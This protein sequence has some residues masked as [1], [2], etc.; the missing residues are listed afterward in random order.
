MAG[1]AESDSTVIQV[2]FT[3]VPDDNPP[4]VIT[5]IL[6][7]PADLTEIEAEAFAG[8]DAQRIVLPASCA[9]VGSRAFADSDSLVEVI[10][11]G[12]DTVIP[13][14]AF[15]GCGQIVTLRLPAGN[16]ST[17][18]FRDNPMVTVLPL[19]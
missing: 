14:D 9:A 3:V 17:V 16:P 10:V 2:P 6:T 13:A 18:A 5:R 12:A 8:T 7:L 1:G 19:N 11:P 4:V 15:D